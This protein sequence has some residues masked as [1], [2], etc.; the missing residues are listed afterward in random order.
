MIF[1]SCSACKPFSVSKKESQPLFQVANNSF[2][3]L[4]VSSNSES[5]LRHYFS[6]SEMRKSVQ[7]ESIFPE[8]CFTIVAILFVSPFIE[9]KSCSGFSWSIAFYTNTL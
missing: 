5:L 9:T 2:L 3:V 7:R 6:P 8:R 4:M 1:E